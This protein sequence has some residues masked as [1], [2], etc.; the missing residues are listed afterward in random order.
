MWSVAVRCWLPVR[1]G[2]NPSPA[3]FPQSQFVVDELL[4]AGVRSHPPRRRM[5]PGCRQ[6]TASS[7]RR[8]DLRLHS[9]N[10]SHLSSTMCC[11][12]NTCRIRLTWCTLAS[13]LLSPFVYEE[14][15]CQ[16]VVPGTSVSRHALPTSSKT[17]IPALV[18]IDDDKSL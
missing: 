18:F 2:A 10:P 14:T 12:R 11:C 6:N 4:V 1:W 7:T 13:S 3:I 5:D 9:H 17:I 16:G 15:F 8:S